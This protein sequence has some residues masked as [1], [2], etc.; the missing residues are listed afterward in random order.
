[1]Q[2]PDAAEARS[3][4]ALRARVHRL[5]AAAGTRLAIADLKEALR[6]D[7]P[8]SPDLVSALGEI[9]RAE[10]LQDLLAAHADADSMVREEIG[11]AVDRISRRD[12]KRRMRLVAARL[13][14]EHG[15]LLR[16][17]ESAGRL[18]PDRPP[19]GPAARENTG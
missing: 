15:D 10:D 4:A 11:R 1:M 2:E 16:H 6:R 5:I 18:R 3:A 8:P 13:S 12:G 19:G 17:L 7:R 9:G 14:P